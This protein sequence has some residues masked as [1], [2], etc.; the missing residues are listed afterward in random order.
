MRYQISQLDFDTDFASFIELSHSIYGIKAVTDEA[1]YRW[2]FEQN[3]YNPNGVHLFH[4]AKD[5]DKVVASDCLMPVPLIIKGQKFLAAWSIKTMTHPDYQRQGIFRAMTE[6]NISRA[7]ELGIDLILGFANANSFPGYTK[8]GWDVLVERRAV[9]RPL[10]IKY[11]LAKRKVFKPFAEIGN[12]LYKSYDSRRISALNKRVGEF[13]P[14]I[15]TTLP[16][17]CQDIWLKMQSVFTT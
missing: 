10:D 6:H 5:G 2:L 12:K 11:T 4:V 3:I 9:V 15:L 1:M 17:S 13:P 7:K 14:N 8:F 16:E